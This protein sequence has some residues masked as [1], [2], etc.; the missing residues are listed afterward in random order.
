MP[1]FT[2][3]D[4]T[5]HTLSG[6]SYGYSGTRIDRLGATEFTLVAIAADASGSVGPF[7]TQIERCVQ[8][9][10]SACRSAPRADNLMLRLVQFDSRL[11]ELHGFRPLLDCA[12][13][14][15]AGCLS[16]GGCTALYD[17][18]HNAV[19]SVTAYGRDLVEQGLSAN[20]IVFVITDGEDNSSQMTAGSVRDAILDAVRSEYIESV[21]TVLVGVNVKEP[22][23]AQSL[24]SFSTSA[25]FDHYLELDD[26]D[27]STLARLAD[28]LSR[29]IQAQSQVLG[30]GGASQVLTF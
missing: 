30:S 2:T 3:T 8:E 25:G 10:V 21:L 27:A 4:L 23:L 20:A 6:S 9:T 19:A 18:T 13:D 16:P 24:L 1:L 12:V 5:A 15:Y 11:D 29:S 7:K 26:A 22:R 28:F 14:R 17:A